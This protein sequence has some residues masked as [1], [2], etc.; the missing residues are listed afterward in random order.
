MRY[1]LN[2]ELGKA[3]DT[4]FCHGKIREKST[5][6]HL[7]GQPLLD[8]ALASIRSSHQRDAFRQAGVHLQSQLAYQMAVKCLIRPVQ[9]HKGACL[10]Y[11][12]NCV[13]FKPPFITLR[14]TCVN[15][16]PIYL[17]E[18][19]SELGLR[20]R[21]NAFLNSLQLVTYGPFTSENS[22]LF[23]HINVENVIGNIK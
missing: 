7:K 22:L 18:F 8:K 1:L 13:L 6:E 19:S 4:S 10:I 21:T 14:V 16:S 5:Y 20:M 17:A 3:I 23:K 15:E 12:L 2:I 9:E 11:G